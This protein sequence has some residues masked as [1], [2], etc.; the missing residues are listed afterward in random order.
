MAGG[1]WRVAGRRQGRREVVVAVAAAA[2]AR[3]GARASGEN[4]M[5]SQRLRAKATCSLQVENPQL[6]GGLERAAGAAASFQ[7]LRLCAGMRRSGLSPRRHQVGRWGAVLKQGRRHFAR[8]RHHLRRDLD[9]LGARDVE[10]VLEVDVGGGEKGMD[11]V[12]RRVLH[13]LVAPLDV[14]LVGARQPRN[15]HRHPACPP[16]CELARRLRDCHR[17][18]SAGTR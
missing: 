3:R 18:G 15:P 17:N 2:A 16:L 8:R 14:L 6:W 7:G 13:R 9:A 5:L 1:G 10:L 11:P 12:E 4:S